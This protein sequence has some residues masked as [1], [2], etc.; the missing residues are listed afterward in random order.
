MQ[1]CSG[2]FL[3]SGAVGKGGDGPKK[4]MEGQEKVGEVLA[5][6]QGVFYNNTQGNLAGLQRCCSAE[7]L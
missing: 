4:D 6:C 7:Q 3:C 1:A 2:V 5:L